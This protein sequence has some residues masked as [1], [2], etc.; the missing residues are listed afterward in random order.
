[1][2]EA[3][4]IFIMTVSDGSNDFVPLNKFAGET[5][6]SQ[7]NAEVPP[8]WHEIL[9][10][11]VV[12]KNVASRKGQENNPLF[13]SNRGIYL[14]MICEY[15]HTRYILKSFGYINAAQQI[16]RFLEDN[17]APHHRH[18]NVR[19]LFNRLVS[20]VLKK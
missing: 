12:M 14:D 10:V 13:V 6:Y 7:L 1:M 11:L 16:D 8:V 20:F 4:Y 3:L 9:D 17:N 2:A 19:N 15:I 5:W 18:S